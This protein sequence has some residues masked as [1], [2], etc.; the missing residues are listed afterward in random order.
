[1]RREVYSDLR[2]YITDII[3]ICVK[4]MDILMEE[5]ENEEKSKQKVK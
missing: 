3:S 1:M 2:L 5:L 4:I